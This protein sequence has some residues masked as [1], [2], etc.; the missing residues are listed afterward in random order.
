[1]YVI[2]D[3]LHFPHF[4]WLEI[5]QRCGRQ[6]TEKRHVV[7]THA[8]WRRNKS[9]LRRSSNRFRE[10]L[11]SIAAVAWTSNRTPK[12]SGFTCAISAIHQHF[13][14]HRPHKHP[15]VDAANTLRYIHSEWLSAGTSAHAP[16]VRYLGWRS[17]H[18]T[19]NSTRPV[20]VGF[21]LALQ[22]PEMFCH[23]NSKHSRSC[24]SSCAPCPQEVLIRST[25]C[26]VLSLPP[27]CTRDTQA[28]G[29]K[30]EQV[31]ARQRG[32]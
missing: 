31:R 10:R 18:S 14:R 28:D 5:S 17:T 26:A 27:H 23:A 6:Y 29:S 8:R 32:E 13:V 7:N 24:R 15:G 21:L 30:Q 22:R 9:A 4:I 20:L 19:H 1:M 12:S 25:C 16:A 3:Y 2:W 11:V